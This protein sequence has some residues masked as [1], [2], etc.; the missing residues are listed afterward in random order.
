MCESMRFHSGPEVFVPVNKNYLLTEYVLNENDCNVVLRF[1]R[2]PRTAVVSLV[3]RILFL[4]SW[5]WRRNRQRALRDL[6][7]GFLVVTID[8][9]YQ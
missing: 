5:E 9:A 6:T 4:L 3:K 2:T 7:C 8:V 1:A